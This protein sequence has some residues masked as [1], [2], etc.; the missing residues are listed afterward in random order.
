MHCWEKGPAVEWMQR[1]LSYK[2][3]SGSGRAVG[4][5]TGSSSAEDVEQEGQTSA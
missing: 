3:S 4:S 5:D 2:C 1:E